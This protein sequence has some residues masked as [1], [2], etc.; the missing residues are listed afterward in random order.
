MSLQ[1]SENIS[2]HHRFVKTDYYVHTG[3]QGN[4][5]LV[6]HIFSSLEGRK[7]PQSGAPII[8]QVGISG[9]LRFVVADGGCI[10]A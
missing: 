1:I 8:S 5:D 9:V 10:M 4:I 6:S 7:Y 2:S 3:L